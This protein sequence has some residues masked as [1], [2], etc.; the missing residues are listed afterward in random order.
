MRRRTA[1]D[2]EGKARGTLGYV[3][4]RSKTMPISLM[5]KLTD[6]L[7][8]EGQ[9]REVLR[10]GGKRTIW[11]G[12]CIGGVFFLSWKGKNNRALRSK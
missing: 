11:E 9:V 10:R 6:D 12:R 3:V 5:G 1:R 2:G 8:E 4:G 7:V